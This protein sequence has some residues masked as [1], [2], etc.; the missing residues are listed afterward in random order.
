MNLSALH[1][2]LEEKHYSNTAQN[3]VKLMEIGETVWDTVITSN[4]TK[5]EGKTIWQ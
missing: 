5:K 2:A 1:E 3:M 4:F